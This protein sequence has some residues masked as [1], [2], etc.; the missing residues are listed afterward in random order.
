VLGVGTPDEVADN[1]RKLTRIFKR[2]SGFVFKEQC[3]LWIVPCVTCA[4]LTVLFFGLSK[5]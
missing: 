5:R 4:L 3:N 1:V 2:D